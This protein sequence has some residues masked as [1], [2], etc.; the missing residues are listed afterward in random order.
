MLALFRQPQSSPSVSSL[1][2]TKKGLSLVLDGVQDPGN[3][4]TIIRLADW[5]GIDAVFCSHHTADAWNPK[6]VQATMG[7]IARVPIIY[8]DLAELLTSTPLPVYG[9]LLDGA[10]LYSQTLSP[11][12]LIVMGSEGTGISAPVRQ[13]INH[14]LLI[15]RYGSSDGAESLNVAIATSIVCAEFRR[16]CPTTA[17][18][19]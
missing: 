19:V 18:L 17:P 7:S 15:P 1:P 16:S 3:L 4:G 6:V 5:F 9:T 12:A 2:W 13:L 8:C 11:D 10:N 14:R